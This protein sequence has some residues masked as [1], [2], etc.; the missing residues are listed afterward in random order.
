MATPAELRRAQEALTRLAANDLAAMWR[1]VSN[2]AE[3]RQALNDVLPS[4]IRTYGEAAAAVAADWYDEARVAAGVRG[5]FRAFPADLPPQ[6][7]QSLARWATETG[8]DLDS[9]RALAEGGA[10]RRIIDWSRQTVMGSSLADPRSDGWQR[11]GAGSCAF[12]AMLIGRGAV[13]SEST[14]DFSS[15]DHCKC[16]AVPAFQGAPRPVKPFK[17]SAR[18]YTA[19]ERRSVRD[20]LAKNYA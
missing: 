15:H 6:G 9:V 4:L 3:A 2:A 18:E 5:S 12:C 19:A 17:P 11:V 13:Y 1:Q 14:A 10:A 8:T 20:Y 7:A 16:A